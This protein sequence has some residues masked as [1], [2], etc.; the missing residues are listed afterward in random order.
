MIIALKEE[1][2]FKENY[3]IFRTNDIQGVNSKSIVVPY[4]PLNVYLIAAR[5]DLKVMNE[6]A[7]QLILYYFSVRMPLIVV[8]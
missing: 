5:S 1:L 8:A 3:S 6:I 7:H 2:V 4:C